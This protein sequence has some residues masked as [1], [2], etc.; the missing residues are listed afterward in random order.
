MLML[1]LSRYRRMVAIMGLLNWRRQGARSRDVLME[2]LQLKS[3]GTSCAAQWRASAKAR[4]TD[5]NLKRNRDL[6]T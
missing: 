5:G 1:K 2:L 4:E 3:P 6:G